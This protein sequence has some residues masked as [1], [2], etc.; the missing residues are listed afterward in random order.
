MQPR[1]LFQGLML[2]PKEDLS[3]YR[4]VWSRHNIF[5]TIQS[6]AGSILPRLA[7]QGWSPSAYKEVKIPEGK[8]NVAVYYDGDNQ[9]KFN[10][11]WHHLIEK[12]EKYKKAGLV[13]KLIMLIT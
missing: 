7:T 9:R 11:D 2:I 6:E 4:R 3:T 1:G 13:R 10:E 8:I 5:F 12:V